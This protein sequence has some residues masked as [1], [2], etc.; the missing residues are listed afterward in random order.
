MSGSELP[1][2]V[3]PTGRKFELADAIA[4]EGA[5]FLKGDD[6]IPRPLRA[7]A[8]VNQFI[9][10]NLSD[11]AGALKP[12]LQSWVRHDIRISQHLDQPLTALA[13]ILRELTEAPHQLYEFS[14]QVNFAWGQLYGERPR[15]QQPGQPPHPEAEYAHD[16]VKSRLVSL[17][18]VLCDRTTADVDA[19]EHLFPSEVPP[20]LP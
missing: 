13:L 18:G 17:L 7:M 11:P 20:D 10:D 9:S 1:D 5:N 2:S 6:S 19:A 14:R 4:R 3:G 15:F 16:E 12:T 8:Q